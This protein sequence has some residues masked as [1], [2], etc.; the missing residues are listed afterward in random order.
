MPVEDVKLADRYFKLKVETGEERNRVDKWIPREQTALQAFNDCVQSVRTVWDVGANIGQ[1]TL[2]AAAHGC[3]VLAFEP[4][5]DN[6]CKLHENQR[7]NGF[8]EPVR[9]LALS[10]TTGRTTIGVDG[11]TMNEAGAGLNAIGHGDL[12]VPT[13]RADEF[14]DLPDVLKVDVEGSEGLVLDGFGDRLSE[15]DIIFVEIHKSAPHRPSAEDFGYSTDRI[16][17]LLDNEGFM[18]ETIDSSKYEQF[19]QATR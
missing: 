12:E 16:I 18:V 15:V 2:I 11:K 5:P 14:P 10:D 7:L 3:D 8:A 17:G 9:G 6:I 19:I 1:Y 4:L 13:R